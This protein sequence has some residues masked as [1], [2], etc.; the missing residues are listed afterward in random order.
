LNEKGE[1]LG[2]PELMDRFHVPVLLEP[3][4][5]YWIHRPDGRYVDA[6]VGDG[7]HT[8]AALRI[9]DPGASVL[10][11][12]RDPDALR[13]AA[14]RLKEEPRVLLR[15]CRY[16]EL[17]NALAELGWGPVDGI[18]A[19]LGI[20]SHQVD[21]PERG[22]SFRFEGPLDMRMDPTRGPSAAEWLSEADEEEIAR[23][24]YEYGEAHRSRLAARCV[25]RERERRAIRTTTDLARALAPVARG[26]RRNS[27]L[28]RYFQAV[29]IQV[30]DELSS[31]DRFLKSAP[32]WLVPGGRLV[33]LAYHSL[34]DRRIKQLFKTE[35]W[36]ALTRK[37]VQGRT[38]PNPRARSAR[39]RAAA[40]T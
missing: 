20:S 1:G 36:E 33:V 27:E 10:C 16:D 28:A 4:L 2:D 12:D 21:S 15:N 31:L 34:E 11:L 35:A 17:G 8:R 14:E 26:A 39:L 22:F 40:R 18:L 19:D 23:V 6:T 32:A 25:V 7:G 30:N 13:R 5:Q 24:F 37:A 29:R 3:V 9:L 38:D